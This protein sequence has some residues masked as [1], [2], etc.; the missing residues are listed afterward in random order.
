MEPYSSPYY[1]GPER[2][3]TRYEREEVDK[4]Y[5]FKTVTDDLE[6]PYAGM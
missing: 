5:T 2:I 1:F 3:S 6:Q 4:T